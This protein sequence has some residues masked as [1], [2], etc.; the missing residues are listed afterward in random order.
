MGRSKRKP[1]SVIKY[2]NDLLLAKLL[3]EIDDIK[4]KIEDNQKKIDVGECLGILKELRI[5]ENK[6]IASID[7]VTPSSEEA[8]DD[9]KSEFEKELDNR[10][11]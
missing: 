1:R 8:S 6:V 9:D 10:R 5:L 7:V 2:I 4:K 11:I 3:K